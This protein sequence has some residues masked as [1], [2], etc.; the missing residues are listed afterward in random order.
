MYSS[1][2]NLWRGRRKGNVSRASNVFRAPC[3]NMKFRTQP[4]AMPSDGLSCARI[5][6]I[7]MARDCPRMR[8]SAPDALVPLGRSLFDTTTG[9][10]A[11]KVKYGEGNIKNASRITCS[12]NFSLADC[13]GSDDEVSRLSLRSASETNRLSLALKFARASSAVL[14]SKLSQVF[15]RVLSLVMPASATAF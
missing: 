8:S 13:R 2:C 4:C 11:R 5:H 7:T 14:R 12:A 10:F 15:S 3:S 6:L 1:P 9:P